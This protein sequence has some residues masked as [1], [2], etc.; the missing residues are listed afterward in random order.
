MPIAR[1]SV[2]TADGTP[3]VVKGA[4]GPFKVKPS[5]PGGKQFAHADSK[6]MGRLGEGGQPAPSGEVDATGTRKVPVLTVGRDGSIQA[7][8][9][10]RSRAPRRARSPCP[11]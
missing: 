3:P 11:A 10:P 1:C 4:E 7:P 5:E 9:P 6:I 2:L 8:A